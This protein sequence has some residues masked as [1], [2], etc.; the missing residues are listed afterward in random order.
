[1]SVRI[2]EKIQELL[3]VHEPMEIRTHK[4]KKN[5]SNCGEWGA[6][7]LHP[8]APIQ[9]VEHSNL[10]WKSREDHEEILDYSGG[11]VCSLPHRYWHEPSRG[12]PKHDRAFILHACNTY[13]ERG[14]EIKRLREQNAELV[15]FLDAAIEQVEEYRP[16]EEILIAKANTVLAAA[17]AIKEKQDDR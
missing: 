8:P 15:F 7:S 4:T 3:Q 10:P 2:G 1:M 14:A 16:G 13:Y 11:L 9:E 17:L 6:G 5:C 12:K